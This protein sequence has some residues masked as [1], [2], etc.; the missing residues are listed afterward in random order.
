LRLRD[1]VRKDLAE[2]FVSRAWWLVLTCIGL[3][4]GATF[5]QAVNTYAEASGIGGGAA[6]LPQALSPLDGILVPT[7]G[8]YDLAIMLLFPFVAIRLVS[9][10]KSS[11]ALKLMLQWPASRGAHVA[12]K[13]IALVIAW[14]VSLVPFAIAL[15]MWRSYGGHL[16][17]AETTNLLAGYTLRYLLTMSVACAAAAIMTGAANAAVVVLAL[18]IGTWALDFLAAG[19]GGFVQALASYTPAALLRSFERGLLRADVSLVLITLTV[20]FFNLTAIFLDLGARTRSLVKRTLMCVAIA[21]VF[22]TAF[23]LVRTSADVSE[24]R[25]NSFSEPDQRALANIRGPLRLTIYLASED[26][27]MNDFQNNVL[28]K[29]NRSMRVEARYPLEG[30]TGLFEDRYGEIDYQLAGK[31]ATNRSTTE[32]IVLDTIYALAGVT[33]PQRPESDYAGYPLA[34]KPRGA[35]WMFFVAWPILVVVVRVRRYARDDT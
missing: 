14:L 34:K 32:E 24:N 20:A 29:L 5:I 12:S 35:A 16:N 25:R 11:S 23:S 18:T 26:P 33:P 1:L 22:A 8:A 19:R 7:L 28:I 13:A 31:S 4:T 3:L 6:A 21:I 30:R 17:A 10:E 27:R 2:L 15:I 9:A